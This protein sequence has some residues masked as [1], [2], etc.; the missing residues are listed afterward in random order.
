[1]LTFDI[2]YILKKGIIRD[3]QNNNKMVRH[4]CNFHKTYI[5]MQATLCT[6]P[7]TEKA[8]IPLPSTASLSSKHS[9]Y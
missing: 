7:Y 6:N 2:I 9:T 1:V 5:I 3:R 8:A 4:T